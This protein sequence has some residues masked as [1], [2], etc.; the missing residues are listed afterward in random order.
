MFS[1]DGGED[2][3]DKVLDSVGIRPVVHPSGEDDAHRIG[4]AGIRREIV[5]VNAVF[6]DCR[7]QLRRHTAQGRR[8]SLR[9]KNAAVKARPCLQLLSSELQVL[10]PV[11]GLP[12]RRA[13][14][15][16]GS[17]EQLVLDVVLV[18][19]QRCVCRKGEGSHHASLNLDEVEAV[20][21]ERLVDCR[22]HQGGPE[23]PVKVRRSGPKGAELRPSFLARSGEGGVHAP[24]R[25]AE[26][27]K[28]QTAV[29][30]R[31]PLIGDQ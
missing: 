25:L 7:W 17:I 4:Q 29:G 18:E 20:I 27:G 6:H 3:P 21:A 23:E 11:V 1:K 16:V 8:F 10:G 14:S 19:D 12:Q 2:V 15:T 28:S 5:E 31:V 26:P 13:L 30:G 22:L 24:D 9:R